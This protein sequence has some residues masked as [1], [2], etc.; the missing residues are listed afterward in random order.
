MKSFVMKSWLLHITH[1]DSDALGCSLVIDYYNMQSRYL[2]DSSKYV[3]NNFNTVESSKNNINTI[4]NV[5]SSLND[6][7]IVIDDDTLNHYKK[8]TSGYNYDDCGILCIPSAI[9]ITDLLPYLFN[10]IFYVSK[11]GKFH[12]ACRRFIFFVRLISAV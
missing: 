8:L 11:H 1:N 9:F 4:I 12:T 10:N 3:I 7:S 5:L 6:E 2:Y